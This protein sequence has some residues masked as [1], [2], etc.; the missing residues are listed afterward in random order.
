MNYTHKKI[1]EERRKIAEGNWTLLDYG[2]ALNEIVRLSGKTGFCTDCVALTVRAEAAEKQACEWATSYRHAEAEFGK[3]TCKGI[4]LDKKVS[5][6]Q[7]IV[8]AY[9]KR[10]GPWITKDGKSVKECESVWHFCTE[11]DCPHGH[12]HTRSLVVIRGEATA[13]WRKPLP[14]DETYYTRE[15]ALAANRQQPQSTSDLGDP[16][17]WKWE[18]KSPDHPDIQQALSERD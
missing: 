2:A 4:A 14:V 5:E 8:D 10:L 16:K 7:A 17:D 11:I 3:C 12:G 6:L 1:A 13:H 18:N 15:A 9:Q